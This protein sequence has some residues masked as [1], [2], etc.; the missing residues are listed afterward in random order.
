LQSILKSIYFTT[1]FSIILMRQNYNYY[2]NN[3]SIKVYAC[4]ERFFS[5]ALYQASH[6]ECLENRDL[7]PP[8]PFYSDS[9]SKITANFRYKHT[10]LGENFG[11]ER[12]T[13]PNGP[14]T[15]LIVSKSRPIII[16][17]ILDAKN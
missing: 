2:S 9:S 3:I 17:F 10:L 12:S 15:P 7:E 8:K 6:K 1:I 14:K 16:K 5:S 4:S 11:V 13:S